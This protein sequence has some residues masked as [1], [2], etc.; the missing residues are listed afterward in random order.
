M[1]NERTEN[2]QP[3]LP[4]MSA[5]EFSQSNSFGSLNA[6]EVNQHF[7][8]KNEPAS[9][10]LP[11]LVV[12]KDN[13]APSEYRNRWVSDVLD[14]GSY[15]VEKGDSLSHIARRVLG[16]SGHADASPKEIAEE[17]KIIAALNNIELNHKG[18]PVHHLQPGRTLAL[19]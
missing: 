2:F 7:C 15:T 16:V 14:T 1:I 9:W 11:S 17:V 12:E 4:T 6:R 8:D 5:V 19:M 10:Q 13:P 3:N 18:H